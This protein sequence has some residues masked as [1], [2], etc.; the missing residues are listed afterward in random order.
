M[1]SLT[2]EFE[3][4]V[5]ND[6]NY[7]GA[8]FKCREILEHRGELLKIDMVFKINKDNG[9]NRNRF[10]WLKDSDSRTCLLYCIQKT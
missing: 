4:H 6:I 1:K 3:K 7:F 2:V 8:F 5:D 9:F 10:L